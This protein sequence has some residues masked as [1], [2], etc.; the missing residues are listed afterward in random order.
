MILLDISLASFKGD[1]SFTI[2]PRAMYV[3]ALLFLGI[4]CIMGLSGL[5][6]INKFELAELFKAEKVSEGK[7]RG[8]L[9][10]LAVSLVLTGTGYCLAGSNNPITVLKYCIPILLLVITGTYIFFN[11]GLPRLLHIL[12][13]QKQLLQGAQPDCD[14]GI[15]AQGED[16]KFRDGNHSGIVR[17]GHNCHIVRVYALQQCL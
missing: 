4:F 10:L 1:I 8:S 2:A 6:V 9:T 7:S 3:T 13:R 16:Y 5:Y 15:I 11:S 17:G 12:K 14:I